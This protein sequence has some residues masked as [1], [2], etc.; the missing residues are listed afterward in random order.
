MSSQLFVNGLVAGAGYST[1]ALSLG[2][3]CNTSGFLNFSFAGIYTFAAYIVIS[4]SKLGL[5]IGLAIV[6]G[7]LAAAT[8][9]AALEAG[10][11][12]Q[13][14]KQGAAPEILLLASFGAL[15]VL[16]NAVSLLWGDR[17]VGFESAGSV[18]TFE[19]LGARITSIQAMMITY[20]FALALLLMAGLG[21]TKLGRKVPRT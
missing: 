5:P 17:T 11:F 8:G 18:K 12:R 13:L 9:A 2:L 21:W 4:A 15:I 10:L 7:V 1:V 19:V 16:Q 3:M 14:R 20:C 6:I